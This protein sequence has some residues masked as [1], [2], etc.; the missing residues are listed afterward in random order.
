MIPLNANAIAAIV[1]LYRRAQEE[2]GTERDHYVFP[3]CENGKIDPTRP[4]RSWRTAWRH[5]TRAILCPVCGKQQ[6]PGNLCRNKNCRADIHNV[7]SPT[8]GASLGTSPRGCSRTTRVRMEAKRKALDAISGGGAEGGYGT[9]ND[10]NTPPATTPPHP[11]VIEMYG[12]PVGLEPQTSTVSILIP[13]KHNPARQCM[14][15]Q[16]N[17][18]LD[19]DL[20]RAYAHRIALG[21]MCVYVLRKQGLWHKARHRCEAVWVPEALVSHFELWG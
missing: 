4:Q 6:A 14:R 12:R 20:P 2:C 21:R 9:N 7:K 16:R 8:A 15:T 10:T 1:D 3:S 13:L 19:N 18:N 17:P 11:Q 5:M